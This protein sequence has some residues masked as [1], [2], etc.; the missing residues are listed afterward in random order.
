MAKKTSP[1][2]KGRAGRGRASRVFSEPN[3]DKI[4][5]FVVI[6]PNKQIQLISSFD[7][8]LVGVINKFLTVKERSILL[9]DPLDSK[10]VKIWE[11]VVKN[12]SSDINVK[13][14]DIKGALRRLKIHLKK[15]K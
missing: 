2:R 12:Y 1:M 6:G 8:F 15:K 14:S 13:D 3:V 7:F 4:Y 11:K 9:K 10:V 5:K